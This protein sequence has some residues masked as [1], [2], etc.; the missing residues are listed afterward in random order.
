MSGAALN[1]MYTIVVSKLAATF[2]DRDLGSHSGFF[3]NSMVMV[4]RQV[5]C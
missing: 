1:C 3:I 2:P 5:Y 4:K